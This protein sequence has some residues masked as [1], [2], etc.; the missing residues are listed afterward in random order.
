M[1]AAL[2]ASPPA[3]TDLA[4]YSPYT[5]VALA[6]TG[7]DGSGSG[8]VAAPFATHF[9]ATLA[10]TSTTT[11]ATI[12]TIIATTTTTTITTTAAAAAAAA[13]TTT[14]TTDIFPSQRG[15]F[16]VAPQ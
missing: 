16:A 14:T 5:I 3:P 10:R 15:R 4:V 11:I 13:A 7:G 2:A 6:A 1:S 12:A 9:A 8:F